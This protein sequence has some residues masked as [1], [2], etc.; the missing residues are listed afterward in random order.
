M[1][2]LL[3]ILLLAATG[4]GDK[5]GCYKPEETSSGIP[6]AHATVTTGPSGMTT[7]QENVKRRIEE[8]NKPGAVKYLYVL[9]PYSGEVM[10]Q[11]TVKGKVTSGGKRLEPPLKAM[12]TD[13]SPN[14][15][16][17]IQPDG[18]WGGSGDYLF[19]WDVQGIYHQHYLT[20]G[21]IVHVS[22]QPMAFGRVTME[23]QSAK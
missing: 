21:Q 22:S 14:S 18:T 6:Q 3:P 7:E 17:R 10:I 4:S 15:S 20:G 12:T 13:D 5:S 1:K 11:S 2:F 8:D 16:E 19:W 23:V 9:S